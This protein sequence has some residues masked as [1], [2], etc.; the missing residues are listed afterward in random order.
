MRLNPRTFSRVGCLIK[1]VYTLYKGRFGPDPHRPNNIG[2]ICILIGAACS[3]TGCER[4]STSDAGIVRVD[5]AASL[6]YVIE[7]LA[8]DVQRELGV[9]IEV[10]AGASGALAQQVAQGDKADLFISANPQ[11]LDWL[12]EQGLVDPATRVDLA[13]N[14]LVVVAAPGV[15]PLE[16]LNDLSQPR[17]QPLAVGDPA[18]V[19]AGRYA[20]QALK[21]HGLEP[22]EQLR[23]AESPNVR[24]A[25]AFVQSGEC[26]AGIIYASDLRDAAG[27]ELLWEVDPSDHDPIRYPA[28]VVRGAS[29]REGAEHV[30]EWLQDE[31]ARAAFR[32]AGFWVAE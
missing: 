9:R 11:W 31:K 25:L 10:N 6:A 22:G 14:R 27:V 15:E 1:R 7:A 12:A 32:E 20:V 29:N 28:A 19:P 8:E 21:A 24:A 17:Y 16:N 23:L 3:I 2:L 30:L 5:A 26:P 18:F 4:G 13:A